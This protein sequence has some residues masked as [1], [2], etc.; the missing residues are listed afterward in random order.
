MKNK[1]LACGERRRKMSKLKVWN[2]WEK[3]DGRGFGLEG[4]IYVTRH[5]EPFTFIF[6]FADSSYSRGIGGLH[7]DVIKPGSVEKG[8]WRNLDEAIEAIARKARIMGD[9]NILPELPLAGFKAGLALAPGTVFTGE[10]RI[11]AFKMFGCCLNF[12]NG[13]A[14]SGADVNTDA[15]DLMITRSVSPFIVGNPTNYGGGGDP[16][17]HTAKGVYWVQRA[18]GSWLAGR[19]SL[20]DI[21]IVIKGAGGKVGSALLKLLYEEGAELVV[22]E[23]DKEKEARI[24][25]LYPRLEVR[26]HNL[27]DGEECGIF[28]PC[29]SA[30]TITSENVE[31]F[32]AKAIIGA[33]NGQTIADTQEEI[34]GLE[35]RLHEKGIFHPDSSGAF[36][37]GGGVIEVADE[38]MEGGFSEE[39]VEKK[40]R[41]FYDKTLWLLEESEKQNKP[42]YLILREWI[43]SKKGSSV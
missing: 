23:I 13:R 20:K 38:L 7:N 3:F 18:F 25:S 30:S 33:T 26:D 19:D 36:P 29:D 22:C 9:K 24:K 14:F 37:N 21:K 39:R 5:S 42:S 40:I 35:D 10:T 8:D 43:K 31:T 32:R 4:V 11:R 34:D 6:C 2:E 28:S 12:F 1:K 41:G 17:P 27:I 15:F 16:S